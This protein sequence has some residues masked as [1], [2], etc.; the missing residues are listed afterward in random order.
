M[1]ASLFCILFLSIRPK[2]HTYS[3]FR[4]NIDA[5]WCELMSLLYFVYPNLIFKKLVIMYMKS[6]VW[7]VSSLSIN[8]S[9]NFTRGFT[10]LKGDN[11]KLA[12]KYMYI[13]LFIYFARVYIYYINIYFQWL[14]P[15]SV[16]YRVT[17]RTRYHIFTELYT[18]ELS[19]KL[20]FN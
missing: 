9:I 14:S 17:L 1:H 13:F 3:K 2:K 18:W 15:Y 19:R 20:T 4:N 11:K 10:C 12:W 16:E 6:E 5:I 7:Q 8:L